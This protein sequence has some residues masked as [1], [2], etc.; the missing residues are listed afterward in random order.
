MSLSL[1]VWYEPKDIN[2]LSS[3]R[4][5]EYVKKRKTYMFIGKEYVVILP[6]LWEKFKD[7]F[8]IISKVSD[9]YVVYVEV[10]KLV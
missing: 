3:L 1:Y 5:W 10:I 9:L 8:Q 2:L 6:H 4:T 7:I